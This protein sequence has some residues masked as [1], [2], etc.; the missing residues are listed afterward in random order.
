[1]AGP[2]CPKSNPTI[3]KVG[4]FQAG[5]LGLDEILRAVLA[6]GL[7]DDQSLKKALV[8][9]ARKNGIFIASGVETTYEQALLREYRSFCTRQK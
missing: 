7:K 8:A 4:T 2:C 3:I 6:S 9:A 5:I 1:M